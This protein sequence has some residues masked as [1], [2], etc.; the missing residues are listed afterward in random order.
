MMQVA[1]S[2]LKEAS[3]ARELRMATEALQVRVRVRARARVSLTLTL[4][5]TL[6]PG[7]QALLYFHLDA[8]LGGMWRLDP[9]ARRGQTQQVEIRRRYREIRGDIGEM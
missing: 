8:G 3:E 5:L 4:T 7:E 2:R 9:P 1:N 6:T